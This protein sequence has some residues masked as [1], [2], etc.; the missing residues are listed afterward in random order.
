[1]HVLTRVPAHDLHDADAV[2]RAGGL[3]FGSADGPLSLRKGRV[4][5]E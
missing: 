4:K 3:N 1:M 5:A 2:H